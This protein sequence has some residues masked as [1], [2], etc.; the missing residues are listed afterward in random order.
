MK[1]YGATRGKCGIQ[2]E[3]MN[4]PAVRFSTQLLTCNFLG[5]CRR[6]QVLGG[7]IQVTK[8]CVACVQMN[9][10]MFLVNQFVINSMMTTQN[11]MKKV[12]SFNILG[13]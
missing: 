8:K 1:K 4:D 3:G 6:D 7:V 2:F 5:K 13:C 12:L 10:A 9:W 11:P